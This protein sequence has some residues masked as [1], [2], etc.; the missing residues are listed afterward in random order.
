MNASLDPRVVCGQHGWWQSCE[1]LGAPSYDPFSADG[2]NLNLL[3]GSDAFDP[4]SGTQ[5]LKSYMCEVRR[6]EDAALAD[7][8]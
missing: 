4:I 6:V 3:I 8:H 2:A 5:P 7:L 1:A